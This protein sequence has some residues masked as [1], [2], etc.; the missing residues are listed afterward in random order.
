MQDPKYGELEQATELLLFCAARSEYVGKVVIPALEEGKVFISDRFRDSTVAYQGYGLGT[1]LRYID[2]LNNRV[3]KNI[4]PDLTFLVDLDPEVGL[5]KV[6]GG[7]FNEGEDKIEGRE[8]EFHERVNEGYR[9][10]AVAEPE[11]FRVISYREGDVEGMQE[12]MRVEVV[13]FISDNELED[14]LLKF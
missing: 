6:V 7:E 1:D 14:D 12:E 10:I 4:K 8:V 5:N 9:K 11:R 13:R 3:C 2:I